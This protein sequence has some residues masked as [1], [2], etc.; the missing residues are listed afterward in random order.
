MSRYCLASLG[1]VEIG[2]ASTRKTVVATQGPNRDRHTELFGDTVRSESERPHQYDSRYQKSE[3]TLE[4][5]LADPPFETAPGGTLE[6]SHA[7]SPEF[8]RPSALQSTV[9]AS[10]ITRN[11]GQ[12]FTNLS[13]LSQEPNLS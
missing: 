7:I 12:Q 13:Y 5:A 4:C 11:T 2:E 10:R 8:Q 9:Q 3:P 1:Q 6:V